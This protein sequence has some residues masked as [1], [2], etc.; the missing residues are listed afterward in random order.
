MVSGLPR[1]RA[2]ASARSWRWRIDEREEFLLAWVEH[3]EGEL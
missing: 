3:S 1:M 2:A